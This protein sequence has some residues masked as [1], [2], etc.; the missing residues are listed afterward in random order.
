M[1]SIADLVRLQREALATANLNPRLQEAQR[2]LGAAV[3]TRN[4][5]V[6]PKMT[7]PTNQSMYEFRVKNAIDAAARIAADQQKPCPTGYERN[8]SGECVVRIDTVPRGLPGRTEFQGPTL[9]QNKEA[10]SYSQPFNRAAPL[11]GMA[12]S[13][14][15]QGLG[16]GRTA[17]TAP[18]C[19]Q[20]LAYA[21]DLEQKLNDNCALIRADGS[22]KFDRD[23]AIK[24]IGDIRATC[25]EQFY[26]LG[27]GP[28]AA[29][30]LPTVSDLAKRYTYAVQQF[31]DM[32]AANPELAGK[33][34]AFV[35][36]GQAA[37]TPVNTSMPSTMPSTMPP[38]NGGGMV[39]GERPPVEEKKDGGMS[40]P[41]WLI[42]LGIGG[43]VYLSK[44]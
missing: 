3:M 6:M 36:S 32:V 22:K 4:G 12:Y 29:S 39:P 23:A 34:C 14:T 15:L 2:H 40:F 37:Q 9:T 13:S 8:A 38:A 28:G 33:S 16:Y 25:P 31:N 27:L 24:L 43:Y 10:A 19:T 5:T 26:G 44:K 1:A 35:A 17:A 7:P 42:L 18:T 21:K 11:P 30:N 41:W 20:L